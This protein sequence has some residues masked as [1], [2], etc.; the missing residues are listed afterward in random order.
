MCLMS[1]VFPRDMMLYD[2]HLT[3]AGDDGIT[4]A[5]GDRG[6]VVAVGRR[7]DNDA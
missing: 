2:N 5:R 3:V 7:L 6:R 1:D 4:V